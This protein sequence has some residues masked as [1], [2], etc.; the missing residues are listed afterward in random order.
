MTAALKSLATT[1]L[2]VTNPGDQTVAFCL[3]PW[4]R[5]YSLDPRSSGDVVFEA[6]SPGVP[7]VFHEPD[8]IVLYAWP[9]AE[10]R[11][12]RDGVEL[13]DQSQG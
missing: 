2:R 10:A 1:R 4:A 12:L 13:D 9:G 11:V 5:L 6:D 3:E 7:E 8:R